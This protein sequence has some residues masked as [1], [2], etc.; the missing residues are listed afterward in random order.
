MRS[1][2][3]PLPG[4]WSWAVPAAGAPATNAAILPSALTLAERCVCASHVP[5]SVEDVPN[6]PTARLFDSRLAQGREPIVWDL[7]QKSSSPPSGHQR[8]VLPRQHTPRSSAPSLTLGATQ[9]HHTPTPEAQ[10]R[11]RPAQIHRCTSHPLAPAD[12]P[13]C[14]APGRSYLEMLSSLI[15]ILEPFIIF[16]SGSFHWRARYLAVWSR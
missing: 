7:D 3:S 11:P 8:Q 15:I 13:A 4:G 5:P 12:G 16:C 10:T 9:P 2:L 6:G 14:C 1:T